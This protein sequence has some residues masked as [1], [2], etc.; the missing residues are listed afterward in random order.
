MITENELLEAIRECESSPS[1]YQKCEKL[2][3]FYYLHDKMFGDPEEKPAAT[4]EQIA[5]FPPQAEKSGSEFMRA[6]SGKDW[7]SLLAILDELMDTI[8]ILQP[9][10]YDAV[11][12]KLQE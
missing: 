3:V 8:K 7:T 12:R 6:I 11:M 10:L 5:G 1:S 4:Q 2:A 9:R